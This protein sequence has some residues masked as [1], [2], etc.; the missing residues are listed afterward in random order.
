MPPGLLKITRDCEFKAETARRAM[1]S[2]AGSVK[3]APQASSD[4]S[5]NTGVLQALAPFKNSRAD[6]LAVPHT[7]NSRVATGLFAFRR[8]A[9][10]TRPFRLNNAA[11]NSAPPAGSKPLLM[12]V[13][14]WTRSAAVRASP[15]A[16]PD[17]G[18]RAALVEHT[19]TG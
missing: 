5:E 7:N 2:F 8:G 12:R 10:A 17:E 18:N 3:S 19:V 14:Q 1:T 11:K 4:G 9:A 13:A 16:M 15:T 6:L